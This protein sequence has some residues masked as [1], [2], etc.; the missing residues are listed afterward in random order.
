MYLDFTDAEQ[1][2]RAEVRSFL[3]E[4]LPAGWVGIWHSREGA[5]LSWDVTRELADKGWLTP[6]WPTAYGGRESSMW[7]HLVLQ[8]EFFARHEPRGGQYMGVNWIGPVIIRYGTDEQK[9][10]LLP[11]IA[12]GRVQWAQLFSEPDA[13]SD[14]A[15]L[16]TTAIL[17][18]DSFIVNGEKVWTSYANM[19]QRGFLLARSDPSAERH[20]GLSA[21]LIDMHA[22]G[23]EVREIPST[24]GWHR[25]HSVSM[26]DV[27]VP[28]TALLGPLNGGW[29]VAMAA[30]PF[31]RL[32]NARYARSTRVLNLIAGAFDP[33]LNTSEADQFAETLALGRVAELL[34]YSA[35]G[36]K[37]RSG[38]LGWEASAAFACNALYEREVAQLAKDVL[39]FEALVA[40]GDDHA[41]AQGEVESFVSLQAPTVTIQAGSYQVQLSIIGQSGLGLP[42]A[43]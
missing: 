27:R 31:E 2:L 33:A 11:E 13:G 19:A 9:A 18:G 16:R 17:D 36:V 3:D 10:T 8:E 42:R 39:G 25:F 15:S 35:A 26:S 12:Q 30:L 37:E 28:R 14:L 4:R 41:P 24:I 23:V 38:V 43:R 32:G 21:L 20:R 34:N 5:E 29:E 7:E 22:A 40:T 6:Q 1:E